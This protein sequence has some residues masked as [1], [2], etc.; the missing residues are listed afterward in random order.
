MHEH[1]FEKVYNH[2]QTKMLTSQRHFMVQ[3]LFFFSFRELLDYLA[4]PK[5]QRSDDVDMDQLVEL[6][7]QKD[8]EAKE[9]LQ[10]GNCLQLSGCCLENSRK[11]Q[12]V[13]NH[14]H[15]DS[16]YQDHPFSLFLRLR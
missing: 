1:G 12:I 15:D 7:V 5:S 3:S 9:L 16:G 10:T 2:S 4:T 13:L 8:K 6:L 14:N 11:V